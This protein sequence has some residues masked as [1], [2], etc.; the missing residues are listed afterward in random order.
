MKVAIFVGWV[1][2]MLLPRPLIAQTYKGRTY[3]PVELSFLSATAYDNPHRDV[4]LDVILTGPGE[5]Q[6]RIAG[7]WDGNL[8]YRARFAPPD[9]GRWRFRTV[10]SDTANTGLHGQEGAIEVAA[11]TGDDPFARKGWPRVSDDQRHFV[12]GDGTPLFLLGDWAAEM[13]WKSTEQELEVYLAD[14]KAKGFNVIYVVAMSHMY[15]RPFGVHNQQGEPFALDDDFSRLNPRYF[16]HLDLIVEKV[17]AAGMVVALFPLWGRMIEFIAQEMG[18]GYPVSV[19]EGLLWARYIGARYAGHNV[20]WMVAGDWRYED[21]EQHRYWA[22]FGRTLQAASGK[23]HLTSVHATG[24]RGS[25]RY[26]GGGDEWLDFHTYTAGHDIEAMSYNWMGARQAYAVEPTKPVLSM[27]TAFEDLFHQFWN[28]QHDTTGARR[29]QAAHVRE[30]AYQ[31]V[32]SGSLGGFTYGANGIWQ[33]STPWLMSGFGARQTAL[34]ALDL[35]GS[36]QMTVLKDLVLEHEWYRLRPMQGLLVHA[37]TETNLPVAGTFAQ[38]LAYFSRQTTSATL[39]LRMLGEEA[40]YYWVNPS[41]GERTATS[42]IQGDGVLSLQAPD[43]ND[44]LFVALRG[45]GSPSSSAMEP[46]PDTESSSQE[47]PSLPLSLQVD[48]APN[49]FRGRTTLYLRLPEPGVAVV[50]VYDTLGRRVHRQEVR[51]N[52]ATVRADLDVA[53]AGLYV[54]R[55]DLAGASGKT[56]S[57]VG[58]MVGL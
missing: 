15:I 37:D 56:Y 38:V 36:S 31:G 11:Y 14:R 57:A 30:A 46:F 13:A 4:H 3:Q 53:A 17:N 21:P 22:D 43:D 44:W 35:P 6:I 41:N 12:Y 48:N 19:D 52:F 34:E 7:F 51:G 9:P 33:W 2:L 32:L 45:A 27:E 10:A 5:R 58:K 18:Y 29:I 26:Y 25:F 55:V 24:F 28:H 50:S 42:M 16:D 40:T 23:R 39:D 1:A 49:P 20:M 47:D 54:Y 8:T